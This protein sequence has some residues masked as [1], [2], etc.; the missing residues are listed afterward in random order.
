MSLG[1]GKKSIHILKVIKL[2]GFQMRLFENYD[3]GTQHC[4]DHK[5]FYIMSLKN[6]YEMI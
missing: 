4:L 5:L 2:Y 6:T 3:S 1:G